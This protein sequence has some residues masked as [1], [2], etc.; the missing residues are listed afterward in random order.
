MPVTRWSPEFLEL[1]DWV[2]REDLSLDDIFLGSVVSNFD[3]PE[4]SDQDEVN[5]EALI[6]RIPDELPILPLRG[7]VVYPETAVPLSIGQPRSIRL[8]DDVLSADDRLIGLV[9]SKDPQDELPG[10]DDLYQ[11]GT[12]ASV[13][14]LFRAPDG[15]IRLLVQGITRFDIKEFIQEEPYL[16]AR[17]KLSPVKVERDLEI[18]ALTR[19][20]RDQFAEIT[21]LVPSVPQELVDAVMTLDDPIQVVYTVANF[22]RLELAEA[23][24][25]LELDSV[26]EKLRKLVNFLTREL[27]MLE[28]GQRIQNQ[29]R[30][31][32]EKVQREY[33]LREQMKAIRSELGEEDDQTVEIDEFH[34]QIAEAAMP[35]EAEKQAKR[36]LDRMSHLPSAAAEYGVIRTYLDWMVTLPWSKMTDDN[37]DISRARKVLDED[38]YGLEDVKER[39]LE[40]LAVRKLRK[41]REGEIDANYQDDIRRIREGVILCFVG[42]PG[43][44]K[45]S[46]GRS[47]ARSMDREFIRISLGGVRDEAEIRGHRRTYIGAMP[48]RILQA[49]RRVGKNNPVFMLDE[50]DKLGRDYRGDPTS[51]LLEVLDPEQNSEFRDHYLEVAYDLSKV[52][53]ITTANLLEPIPSPLR[54]R[55]EIIKLSGYTDNEKKAI[56]KG[57]LIPRQIR[58]NGLRKKEISFTDPALQRIIRS[59]TRESGV[60]NLER[61]IGSLCRKVVTL[62]AEGKAQKVNIGVKEV[63]EYLGRPRYHGDEELAKRTS[64]PGVATGLAWTSTGGEVLFVEATVMPGK[65]NFQLTGS[66]GDVM[67]ESAQAALSYVRSKAEKLGLDPDFYKNQDIHL[68][69]PA[70][71]Q[72]KDGPSA[73]VTMATALVSLISNRPVKGGVCMTGEITLRGQVLPVGGIKEK[74]LAAYRAGSKTVI[75]PRR[76]Q[77]DLEED[78]PQEVLEKIEFI[79]VENIEEVLEAALTKRTASP[80][81][82]KSAK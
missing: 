72:P 41:E 5:Q 64:L 10:P 82:A 6:G 69:V 75:L 32:I 27:E 39:I 12:V 47:I 35:Q 19:Q 50:I 49:L 67:K 29:A 56:A 31:E 9:T 17:I 20:A 58:E 63:A 15:T 23:Q 48:G 16:Q 79:F 37:L 34:R 21:N 73:G 81:K 42:P 1:L 71:A 28:I 62:I 44:G 59:Y 55:M 36:E 46:L 11:V 13:H 26:S 65:N 14:R 68:H 80:P 8:V 57:Y 18:D 53:F 4:E 24:E 40:F 61:E 38:H 22:Q 2:N 76:N 33:F 25:L 78:I 66:L 45:T 77:A 51:A 70:G 43:V 7:L 74:V 30:S 54:D 52:M 3:P 60:R